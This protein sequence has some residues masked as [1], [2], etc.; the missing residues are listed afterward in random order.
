[1]RRGVLIAG[2]LGVAVLVAAAFELPGR[3]SS[4]AP[5]QSAVYAG[6]HKIRHVVMITQENRSFDSYF[7]TYPGADG[8]PMRHG[9]SVACLPAGPGK[10]CRHLFVDHHDINGGGPHGYV[11]FKRDYDNGAMNGFLTQAL[12]ARHSCQD[13][14][15]PECTNGAG[16]DVLGY[17]TRSDI[18]NYWAYAKHYGL[19]D[20]FFEAVDSWSLPEHLYEV[21]G[22]SA[23][24]ANSN[25]MSCR[26]DPAQKRLQQDGAHH[27]HPDY[28]WTD[29]T[30]L[31]Y[32]HGVSWGYYVKRGE[33]PDCS[34]SHA[35]YCK[36]PQ[37][38]ARTPGRWNP[39]PAFE[40][41][42]QDHQLSNIQPV[43]NFVRQAS[44]GTLPEVS[45]VVPS[46]GVS[47][48]PPSKVSN[49]Q[50]FVTH[51]IDAVMSGPD[52]NSTAIFLSWDDW[53][54]FY[55]HVKPPQVDQ[56]GYGFRVPS[57]VIS[58]YAKPGFIDHQTLSSDAYL[59]FI[60]DDFL[61]GARIDPATDGRPDPRPDIRE[62]APILGD[63]RYAFDFR[64]R[65][66]PPLI[67]PI[68]PHTTLVG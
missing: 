38:A 36:S 16:P 20:H 45:W 53:G 35:V 5:P 17:H 49:G 66:R 4:A 40:T 28:A 55:D 27:E 61:N 15:D 52:W 3:V 34:N 48:H 46:A 32:K 12:Q 7:G 30:Y 57:L 43:G 26:N 59:A 24:C 2:G 10:P 8:I 47:E 23:T 14:I 50:S 42:H 56:N 1:M 33:Q 67:L 9:H 68:D 44:H 51:L 11:D 39:L 65:P 54:G 41:V 31:M 37:Q 62:D 6:I 29:L 22:W 25:P 18:P 58:P 13:P 21:S 64:Q 60:E 63:L 19:Q